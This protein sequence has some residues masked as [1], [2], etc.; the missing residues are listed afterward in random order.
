[1]RT[2]PSTG[3]PTEG[4]P[5]DGDDRCEVCGGLRVIEVDGFTP[6]RGH[7]TYTEDCDACSGDEYAD[8]ELEDL[9][10]LERSVRYAFARGR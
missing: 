4:A 8:L 10:P 6:S 3:G 1:M 7:F 2:E 5:S 9:A